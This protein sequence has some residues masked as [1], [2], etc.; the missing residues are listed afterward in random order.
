MWCIGQ[1]RVVLCMCMY[2]VVMMSF[3]HACVLHHFRYIKYSVL[4]KRLVQHTSQFEIKSLLLVP[5]TNI[6]I[7]F[8]YYT[9]ENPVLSLARHLYISIILLREGYAL[10]L[11]YFSL[12]HI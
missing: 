9:L 5:L 3:I 2:H 1:N 6:T 12:Y 10:S 4:C 7:T 8:I 11:K